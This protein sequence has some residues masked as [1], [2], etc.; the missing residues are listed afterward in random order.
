MSSSTSVVG[1]GSIHDFH[2][3]TDAAVISHSYS[4]VGAT[5]GPAMTFGDIPALDLAETCR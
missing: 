3:N 5:T 4:G 1:N 2:D